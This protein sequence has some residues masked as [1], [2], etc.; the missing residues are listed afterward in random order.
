MKE[1]YNVLAAAMGQEKRLAQV[2]NNLANVN[3]VGFK[4]DSAV[5]ENFFKAAESE[6]E[7]LNEPPRS[8]PDYRNGYTDFSP[9]AAIATGGKFDLM[10]EGDGFFKVEGE[11]AGSVLYTRAGNFQLNS[12]GELITPDGRRVLSNTD[13][14]IT[15]PPIAGELAIAADGSIE[16][17]AQAIGQI[18]IAEFEDRGVLTKLGHNLYRAPDGTEAAETSGTEVRQGFL[19]G[20][21]ASPIQEMIRLIETQRAFEVHQKAMKSVDEIV[22]QRIGQILN[23]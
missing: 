3:T 12:D 10:L 4:Q 23:S 8:V 18:G 17:G 9:G 16:I 5:F 15:I 7:T 6:T 19:E 21:N 14:P 11:T 13:A 20:S 2:A 22:G 1:I